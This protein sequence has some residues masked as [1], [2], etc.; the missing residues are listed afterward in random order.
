MVGGNNLRQYEC[1]HVKYTLNQVHSRDVQ[2]P[3][4]EGERT[5]KAEEGGIA[6]KTRDCRWQSARNIGGI[7]NRR[8]SDECHADADD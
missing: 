3:K 6:S 4:N 2:A 7:S 1:V 5:R 8:L